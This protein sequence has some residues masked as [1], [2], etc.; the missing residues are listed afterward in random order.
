MSEP[1]IHG[2]CVSP[3][4]RWGVFERYGFK[5]VYCGRTAQETTLEIDHVIPVSKGGTNAERNLVTAC[6]ECNLGKGAKRLLAL[7][8]LI[9][10]GFY[11]DDCAFDYA[12]YMVAGRLFR[13]P[14]DVDVLEHARSVMLHAT[15]LGDRVCCVKADELHSNDE[16]DN[17]A[18]FE[19]FDKW[20]CD[21]IS[22]DEQDEEVDDE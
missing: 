19:L 7:P 6:S 13:Q 15:V 16:L 12:S 14:W 2:R 17:A 8:D 3:S 20:A 22:P 4:K 5:C 10:A 18:R 21:L 1:R 11:L 9:K